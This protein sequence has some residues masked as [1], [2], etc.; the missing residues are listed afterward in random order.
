[1][2]N[3]FRPL[4]QCAVSL[5]CWFIW[6]RLWVVA[7]GCLQELENKRKVQLGNPKSDSSHLTEWLLT[8]AF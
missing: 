6:I 2:S 5:E 1:M 4:V 7:G 3:F 8:T